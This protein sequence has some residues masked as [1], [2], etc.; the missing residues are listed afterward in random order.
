MQR[1]ECFLEES[2]LTDINKKI[3]FIYLNEPNSLNALS[4]QLKEQLLL[5]LEE[6]EK[7]SE[8][9]F[10]VLSGKGK[11]FCAG[12]DVKAMSDPYDPLDIHKAMEVSKQITEKIRTMPKIFAS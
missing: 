11:A 6:I 1:W 3:A 7:N 8:V 9:K 2:I 10:V 12:G 5:S 4:Q